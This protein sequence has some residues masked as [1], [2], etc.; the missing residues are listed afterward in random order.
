MRLYL[1]K[2]VENWQFHTFQPSITLTIAYF[3]CLLTVFALLYFTFMGSSAN[4]LKAHG[5][6]GPLLIKEC[7]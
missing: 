4:T 2:T 1:V 3:K 7:H 5:R 6:K